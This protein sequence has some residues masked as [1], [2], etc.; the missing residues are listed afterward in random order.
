MAMVADADFVLSV[1][2]VAT[3]MTVLFV[4]TAVGAVYVVGALLAVEAELKLPHDVLPQVTDQVTPAFALSL[5]T[6][7]VRLVVEPTKREVGGVG[8]S[9][10]EIEGGGAAVTVMV[11]DAVFVLSV[12]DVATIVT[13]LFVGTV[14]GA[15]YVVGALLAVEVALKLP[16]GALPQVT[17]QV[18]PPLALSLLTTAVRFA[19]ADVARDV[20]AEKVTEM[21]AGGGGVFELLLQAVSRHARD[22]RP[23]RVSAWR[24]FN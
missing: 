3:T 16:H 9:A 11:F 8:V 1:T 18:T 4:G 24:S 10:T 5:V 7:A 12:T 15:V 13:V 23:M 22:V 2:E 20:G 17:D 14:E 6:T 21:T 19:V